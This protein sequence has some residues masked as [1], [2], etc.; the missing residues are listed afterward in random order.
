MKN[1]ERINGVSYHWRT[2]EFPDKGFENTKQ[3]GVIAQE[4]EQVYP[5]LVLTNADGFKTVD[6]PKLTA[7]LLEAIKEQQY[8]IENL[9]VQNQQFKSKMELIDALKAQLDELTGQ[10]GL[11]K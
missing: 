10:L 6:Y 11:N 9:S 8:Q 4:L 5:E 1:L 3:I 2:N 7:V